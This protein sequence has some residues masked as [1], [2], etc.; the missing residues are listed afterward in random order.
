M[1]RNLSIDSMAKKSFLSHLTYALAITLLWVTT[2][3]AQQPASR[4]RPPRLTTDDVARPQ[5]PEPLVEAKQ[6]A[7]K[8]EDAGKTVAAEAKPGEAKATEAKAD[9][10]ESSWRDQVGKA[11]TRAKELEREAE[12]A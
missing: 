8:P 1:S 9:P 5:S 6:D 7:V 2:V 11:R 4:Q 12:E 3:E 10:E